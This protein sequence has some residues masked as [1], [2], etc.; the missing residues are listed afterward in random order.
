MELYKKLNISDFLYQNIVKRLKRKPNDF[1]TYL[2]SAMHSEHCGYLHSKKYLSNFYNEKNYE[3][4]NSGCIRFKNYCIFFKMES[5]N[6]PCAIEPYQGS[7]TGIGGI[8]RDVLSLSAKPIALLNSLKFGALNQI[9]TKYYLNEV[10]RGISDYGNS[11]GVPTISGETIFNECFNTIPLVNVLAL[12]IAEEKNIKFSSAKE[13]CLVVLVGSKTGVDGLNGASFASCA[14]NENSKR[15]SVQ[16]ADPYTKKKLINATLKINKLKKVIACQDLGASGILSSTSEMAYKGNCG[17]ELYLDK[18]HTQISSITPEEIMLS[19]SQERM[20]FIVEDD[21][22]TLEKI[23]EISKEN[24]LN[25]SII[26][27]TIKPCLY[28]VYNNN[29]LLCELDLKVLCEPFLYDLEKEE[30]KDKKETSKLNPKEEFEKLLKDDNFSS[31]EKIYS[32]FDQEVQGR[33]SFSQK[34][35]SIGILYLKEVDGFIG[36]TTKTDVNFNSKD[37]MKN[38]FLYCFRKLISSGIEPK[39]LT[40]CLNFSSP[41][42]KKTA[43]DFRYAIDELKKLSFEYKIPVVS[44][45]VSFYN[46]NQNS[47]IPPCST[48]AF[49]GIQEDREKISLNKINLKDKIY[50]L[51][52]NNEIKSKEIIFN[53]LKEK[54]AKKVI[55][56]G[57]YGLIGSLL[58]DVLFYDLGFKIKTEKYFEKYQKD[59]IVISNENIENENLTL[60]GEIVDDKIIFDNYSYDKNE[61]KK[62]FNSKF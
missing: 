51:E 17:V 47:K 57:N 7:M 62:I 36:L 50:L 9:K 25:Y 58:K 22:K 56:I 26:G 42:N 15:Q 35:N 52:N 11:I 32:Q 43:S 10:T 20:A 2:F 59:Y 23:D 38:A 60:I 24:E 45:N 61:I 6:H 49:V 34:E 33:T 39:G 13:N 28:R 21:K 12:G 46:E 41:E 8:V 40:N 37:G 1:E 53:L 4:E 48:L 3:N 19:E 54:K 55:N 29:K 18:V 5:H 16:I 30:I 44:G 27:K 14:I 31:K